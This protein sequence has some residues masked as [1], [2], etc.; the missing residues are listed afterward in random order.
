MAHV[1]VIL[2]KLY[3]TLLLAMEFNHTSHKCPLNRFITLFFEVCV[4][5]AGRWGVSCKNE[6]SPTKFNVG[7]CPANRLASMN[8][9]Q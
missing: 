2:M 3:A 9:K 1:I 7:F 4:G 5:K 6:K 8:P